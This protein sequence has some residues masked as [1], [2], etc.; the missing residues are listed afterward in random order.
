MRTFSDRLFE[1]S[2]GWECWQQWGG[3]G[4]ATAGW[5]RGWS[6]SGGVTVGVSS[7]SKNHPSHHKYKS[8]K[9][10]ELKGSRST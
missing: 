9:Q 4:G 3:G 1:S 8:P 7:T 6:N 5:G 10:F 2:H